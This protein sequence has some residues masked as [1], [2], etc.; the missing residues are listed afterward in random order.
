MTPSIPAD[1]T[2]C[3]E[4]SHHEYER[5]ESGGAAPLTANC[6]RFDDCCRKSGLDSLKGTLQFREHIARCLIPRFRSFASAL[7]IACLRA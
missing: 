1:Q 5:D 7:R 2:K 4:K 3:Q 6:G